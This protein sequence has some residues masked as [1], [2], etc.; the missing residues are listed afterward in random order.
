[1]FRFRFVFALLSL[2]LFVFTIAACPAQPPGIDTVDI[3]GFT[4]DSRFL[5]GYNCAEG[6]TNLLPFLHDHFRAD[7]TYTYG[8]PGQ[9]EM[10]KLRNPALWDSGDAGNLY[11]TRIKSAYW[12][13]RAQYPVKSIFAPGSIR[14]AGNSALSVEN[15]YQP[16]GYNPATQKDTLH[17][18]IVNKMGATP[19]ATIGFATQLLN[20]GGFLPCGSPPCD[21]AIAGNPNWV[22]DA[23]VLENADP[24]DFYNRIGDS[25]T[26]DDFDIAF[27]MRADTSDAGLG[28]DG[29]PNNA[30][31][32][33][34]ILYR[35]DTT[36][37]T[38]PGAPLCALYAP[39]DTVFITKSMYLDS[40]GTANVHLRSDPDDIG[41]DFREFYF[42]IKFPTA[43]KSLSPGTDTV[44]TDIIRW[45]G[46]TWR[47]Y[48]PSAAYAGDGA[49]DDV[50]FCAVLDSVLTANNVLPPGT[51]NLAGGNPYYSDFL[52]VFHTTR[53]VRVDFLSGRVAR[54]TYRLMQRGAFDSILAEDVDS[55]LDDP[56][57]DT[58]MLRVAMND[59]VYL[60]RI[61]AT[62]MANARVARHL[63]DREPLATRGT[64]VN[65]I[66]EHP[67]CRISFGDLDSTGYKPIQHMASQSYSFGG[68]IPIFYADPTPLK[69]SWA[70]TRDYYKMTLKDTLIGGKVQRKRY[71]MGPNKPDYDYYLAE[72][73]IRLGGIVN[74]FAEQAGV[75]RSWFRRFEQAVPYPVT[76]VIQV[77][78]F[79]KDGG[80]TGEFTYG[81][82]PT[83][84]EEI[85][86][87][88]WLALHGGIDGGLMFSDFSWEGTEIGVMNGLTMDDSTN[89]GTL[90]MTPDPRPE[91]AAPGRT[92]PKMWLG[93]GQRSSMV[94]SIV[95]EFKDKIL[96]VYTNLDLYNG[97]NYCVHAQPNWKEAP[98][99]AD[100]RAERVDAFTVG[101]NIPTG[102]Y[103]T[104]DSAYLEAAV[105]SP[106]PRDT[107]GYASDARYLIVTNRRLW[108]VAFKTYD[109][110]SLV[111]LDTLAVYD[112][113]AATDY[114]LSDFGRIDVRRPVV[115]LK[116]ST[117]TMADSVLV[118]KVGYE[119]SWSQRR[120]FGD[121]IPLDY[122]NPGA[123][124]MYRLT[125]I[126]T[127]VSYE[128][129]AF[130]NAVR[131]ENPST[132]GEDKP[133][134]AVVERDS[135][136]YLRTYTPGFGWTAEA[137]I[138]AAADTVRVPS[139]GRRLAHNTFPAIATVRDDTAVLAVWQRV[140][141]NNFGT[142]EALWIPGPP[143]PVNLAN[144]VPLRLSPL[145]MLNEQWMMMTPAVTGLEGGWVV[146]YASPRDGIDVVALRNDSVPNLT[147][148][149][150]FLMKV[151]ASKIQFPARTPGV[152]TPTLTID[153]T[154]LFPTLA[155]V[156]DT[157]D[158]LFA[159]GP[160]PAR[161]VHL[162][163]QQSGHDT[164]AQPA[165]PFI[166]YCHVDVEFNTSSRPKLHHIT[167]DIEHVTQGLP[168]CSF[169][170]PS[171]GVDSTRIGVAF[172]SHVPAA[173]FPIPGPLTPFDVITLRFRDSI[174]TPS[175]S[176]ARPWNL[177]VY[178][179]GDPSAEY[180]YPSLTLFPSVPRT[181]LLAFPQGGIA[182]FDEDDQA[183]QR[184]YRFGE[185]FPSDLPDGTF[186]TM[187]L[188]P[189]LAS[190]PMAKTG[191]LYRGIEESSFERAK[192]WGD[193][194]TY[195]PSRLLTNHTAGAFD[196][197]D[198]FSV[199]PS[200]G[201]ISSFFGLGVWQLL[202]GMDCDFHMVTGA[203]L[204]DYPPHGEDDPFKDPPIGPGFFGSTQHGDSW[205]E[206]TSQ[207][208]GIVS[209]TGVFPAGLEPVDIKRY[210]ARTANAVTW[211]NT[212]PYDTVLNSQPDVKV[213]TEL[214]RASD[215]VVLWRD[216]TLSVRSMSTDEATDLVSVP[217]DAYATPGTS[218]Y[219]RLRP[220]TTMNM[221]YSLT[222]GYQYYDG[223]AAG[224]FSKRANPRFREEGKSEDAAGNAAGLA[225]QIVP[226]PARESAEVR[227]QTAK[228]GRVRLAVYNT[229]GEKLATLP[230]LNA[231]GPGEYAVRISLSNVR[232]GVYFLRA[233]SEEVRTSVRFTVL[234]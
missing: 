77:H 175:T 20:A 36:A 127:G 27:V 171:I 17:R 40:A 156:P 225:V 180:A 162:A 41:D 37:Q 6:D 98:M 193:T 26:L 65:P 114:S 195:Y 70:A 90:D 116:N 109:S 165:G 189:Y 181:S 60:P 94:K 29:I 203:I 50:S 95:D 47:P 89:Y 166:F 72:T 35:R 115:V 64:W 63:I 138:S 207:V 5:I 220:V 200:S 186:P 75:A 178:Y 56:L 21:L 194:G 137:R 139:K 16:T 112:T 167:T 208:A 211:L 133:V 132:D 101:S 31:V 130:N 196:F 118:E 154:A 214:V 38:W 122:L 209:R 66:G 48:V 210:V 19:D 10:N 134:M 153:S 191:V 131:S 107:A 57:M 9:S 135:S 93:F 83:T 164:L 179:W 190:S 216:D 13:K 199:A 54:H 185:P 52:W 145:R 205:I 224:G 12:L 45:G 32:A 219:I 46:G 227:I 42:P 150:S 184:F 147:D 198:A 151:R 14:I 1:M 197:G 79:V 11:L 158:V 204:H 124:S 226:N 232:P 67:T 3:P 73:Q 44:G 160:G 128:G 55:V 126:A 110:V 143:T 113:A 34:G 230:D 172:E 33:Y 123:G 155:Y 120:A 187:A 182:W 188:S 2:L 8:G 99:I 86:V 141:T 170:H 177:P 169:Y 173:P 229:L 7:Y 49:G 231:E 43:S 221:E 157:I 136:V 233:E 28:D 111:I 213:L 142:I 144:A 102:L 96:P 105:F 84:P 140:D 192:G 30:V 85:S 234:Q 71:I 80:Y 25:S 53:L 121:T 78:G 62:G 228:A 148:D 68:T 206:T 100:M 74:K 104:P 159:A 58:T 92:L 212:F 76:A 176:G 163:W 24:V 217:V 22:N 15:F 125:P 103:D 59:E 117:Q 119:G 61:A 152:T 97:K 69:M 39:F 201:G 106:T 202:P 218:V 87:Q 161:P 108:P 174:L 146:A 91:F 18:Q 222:G 223:A 51:V 4:Y 81:W 129:T 168:G 149:L 82:R 88:C 23:F 183:T 215:G